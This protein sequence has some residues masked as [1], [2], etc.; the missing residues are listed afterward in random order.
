MLRHL[1]LTVFV[2]IGSAL[3]G[4]GSAAF[5]LCNGLAPEAHEK[6]IYS[7]LDWTNA[8]IPGTSDEM[9]YRTMSTGFL[10]HLS[11]DVPKHTAK[12][13][14]LA[15]DELIAQ[16][17]QSDLKPQDIDWALHPG[18]LAVLQGGQAALGLTDESLRASFNIY[19]NRGNISSVAVLAVLDKL[20]DMGHGKE[21]VIACSFGPGLTVEAALLK[22][23]RQPLTNGRSRMSEDASTDTPSSVETVDN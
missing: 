4:D 15:Y 13:L 5:M 2:G 19:Q 12:A 6:G 14:K 9:S 7:L 21:D 8:I 3:F 20:R 10:L 23:V 16:S 17:G 1:A 22:R 11:K 18:G